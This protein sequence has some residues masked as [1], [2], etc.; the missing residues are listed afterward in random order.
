VRPILLRWRRLTVHSY[1]ALLFVGIV[2]GVA[3]GNVAAHAAG[4]D[5][6]RA[7]AATLLLIAPALA[8]ARLLFVATHWNVYRRQPRRI[9]NRNEGGAAQYGGFILAL[10]CSVPLVRALGLPFGAYWDATT[11]A[12]LTGM[13]ITRVGCLLNGCCAGRPSHSW[14]TLYLPNHLGVWDRRIPTPCLEAALAGVLLA[15]AVWAWPRLPFPGALFLLVA[16]GYA[17]G[18]L[19]LESARERRAGLSRFTIHHGI[20]AAVIVSSVAVLAVRWP[21]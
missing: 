21:R 3:A 19:V 8:G 14:L 7:Y 15:G 9:W 12:I 1:P 10:L 5:A 13:I 18:R 17:T 16:T 6:R 2:A 20:S 4:L 11:F